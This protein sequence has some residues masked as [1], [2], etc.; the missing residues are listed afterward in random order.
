MEVHGRGGGPVSWAKTKVNRTR[1]K[2][3]YSPTRN[4]YV[5]TGVYPTPDPVTLLW[6]I[7]WRLARMFDWNSAKLSCQALVSISCYVLFGK[8]LPRNYYSVK[9]LTILCILFWKQTTYHPTHPR[10]LWNLLCTVTNCSNRHENVYFGNALVTKS[11][12]MVHWLVSD[13][14][15]V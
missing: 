12:F 11:A 7:G 3:L 9:V 14:L 8:L 5:G 6:W 4:I 15:N 13:S 1:S 10:P 2:G